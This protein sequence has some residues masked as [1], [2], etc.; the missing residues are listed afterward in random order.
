MITCPACNADMPVLLGI[1]GPLAHLRC[2][3]CGVD[4]SVPADMIASAE[5]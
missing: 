5:D 1:L 4:Y 2:R 3:H